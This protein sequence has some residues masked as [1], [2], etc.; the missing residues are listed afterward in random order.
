MNELTE[1]W[2]ES[3][4]TLREGKSKEP[5]LGKIETQIRRWMGR[6]RAVARLSDVVL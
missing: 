3:E 4:A 5:S 6:N 1:K 2:R